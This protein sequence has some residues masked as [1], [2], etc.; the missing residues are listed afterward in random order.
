MPL[1]DLGDNFLQIRP[2]GRYSRHTAGRNDQSGKSKNAGHPSPPV[3]EIGIRTR[4]VSPKTTEIRSAGM[5]EARFYAALVL[6]ACWFTL[7]LL[8]AVRP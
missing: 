6:V 7:A 5:H 1:G 4:L 8:A 3:V 2:I